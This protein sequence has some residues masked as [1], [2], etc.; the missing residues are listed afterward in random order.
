MVG[1]KSNLKTL[2]SK[3]KSTSATSITQTSFCQGRTTRWGL[4]WT[5]DK[6]IT[7]PAVP[8]VIKKTKEKPLQHE[9]QPPHTLESVERGILALLDKLEVR[10]ILI[11][12]LKYLQV[13]S[14]KHFM[15]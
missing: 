6:S 8:V 12:D 4:A 7:L 1:I 2:I 5:Y 11:G 13:P 9:F 10:I 15:S 3:L 14:Q